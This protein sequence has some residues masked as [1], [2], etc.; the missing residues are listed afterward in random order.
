MCFSGDKYKHFLRNLLGESSTWIGKYRLG[1]FNSEAFRTNSH[2]LAFFCTS[3]TTLRIVCSA[4]DIT[5]N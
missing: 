1:Y 4:L 2:G 5:K 3:Q